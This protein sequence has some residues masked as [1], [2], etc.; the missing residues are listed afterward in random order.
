M[1]LTKIIENNCGKLIFDCTDEELFCGLMK[2][3][4]EL[5]H[6]T[7]GS[8]KTDE[9]MKNA[10][11]KALEMNLKNLGIYNEVKEILE[12]Y[13]KDFEK[14]AEIDTKPSICDGNSGCIK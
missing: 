3:V 7:D 11:G 1:D 2:T 8:E 14:V 4:K 6:D 13:D 5:K 12:K 9:E 10:L